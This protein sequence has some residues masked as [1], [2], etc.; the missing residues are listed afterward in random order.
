MVVMIEKGI[1]EMNEE[2]IVELKRCPFCGEKVNYYKERKAPSSFHR[3][4]EFVCL[5]E[6]GC[7]DC[8][9]IMRHVDAKTLVENWN[10]TRIMLKGEIVA[11]DR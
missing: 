1:G 11:L 9:V 10:R 8:D 4:G 2:M 3:D 6:I 7:I 5:Y